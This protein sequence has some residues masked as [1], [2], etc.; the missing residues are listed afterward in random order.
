MTYNYSK[1]HDFE[2]T[3]SYKYTPFHGK[4]FVTWFIEDRT[5]WLKVSN[6]KCIEKTQFE[7][8]LDCLIRLYKAEFFGSSETHQRVGVFDTQARLG[9]LLLEATHPDSEDEIREVIRAL[10]RKYEVTQKIFEYYPL[11]FGRGVGRCDKIINY[12]LFGL[13]LCNDFMLNQNLQ[14]L[15]T[16]IKLSDKLISVQ[17]ECCFDDFELK[18]MEFI[19]S[20][21]ILATENIGNI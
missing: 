3:K 17:Q 13:I 20:V 12:V 6:R 7:G 5:A 4:A 19:I 10:T 9:K 1:K 14:S 2:E 8:K 15:S 16:L 11:N 21:E 18:C